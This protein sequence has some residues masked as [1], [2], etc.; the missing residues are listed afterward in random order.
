M[1][2]GEVSP[3]VEGELA[4]QSGPAARLARGRVRARARFRVRVRVRVKRDVGLGLALAAARLGH[5]QH[6]H[7]PPGCNPMYLKLQPYVR[8]TSHCNPM[9]LRLQPYVSRARLGH[10]EHGHPSPRLL[11]AGELRR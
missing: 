4:E 10:E 6:G 9:Y 5:E 7:P 8:L 11:A 2:V 1:E 3:R